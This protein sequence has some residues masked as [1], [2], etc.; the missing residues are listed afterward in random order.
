MRK[1]FKLAQR[2]KRSDMYSPYGEVPEEDE[3]EDEFVP[4]M[5]SPGEEMA[6][7]DE[8][9]GTSIEFDPRELELLIAALGNLAHYVTELPMG[10]ERGGNVTEESKSNMQDRISALK[11]K[12][13]K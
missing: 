7:V 11:A 1:L 9:D 8:P 13:R 5:P 6:K 2:L 3:P 12:L 10:T 4:D